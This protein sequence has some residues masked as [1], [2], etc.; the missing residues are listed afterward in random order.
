MLK[1][2]RNKTAHYLIPTLVLVVLFGFTGRTVW[3]I[4]HG[5]ATDDSDIQ[6]GMVVA[7]SSGAGDANKVERA[8][9]ATSQ[10][11][12]GVV[13]TL[14]KSLVT[15]TSGTTQLLVESD[16]QIEAYVSDLGGDVKKGDLLIVSPLK[17][18]VMKSDNSLTTIVGIAGQDFGSASSTESYSVK[19]GD[20][21]KQTRIAK[22]T[23]N[24]N[25]QGASNVSNR[26]V[27][28]S[29]AKLGRAV[30]GKEVSEIR[31]V[32]GLVIFFVVLIAEGGILYGA[33]SSSMTAVGR[34]PLARKII[35]R[36]LLRVVIIAFVVLAFGLAFIYTILRV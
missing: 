15:V 6:T 25:R 12:V 28:S 14:D 5:Y 3:A 23:I 16:G 2:L 34:N 22:L 21:T 9:Q 17:G 26:P 8:T 4:A 19:V 11:V 7:L 13:T 24:L 36:E 33:I 27:E 32:V 20:E 29:V 10:K 1:M 30:V 18:V 31:V 35:R